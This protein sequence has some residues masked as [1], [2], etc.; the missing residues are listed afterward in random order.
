MTTI[1]LSCRRHALLVD[2][3]ASR[4]EP[5]ARS[6]RFTIFD[7]RRRGPAESAALDPDDMILVHDFAPEEISNN[8][9]RFVADELLPILVA[10]AAGARGR[11]Q[12][13]FERL[14]GAIV[15]SMD[16]DER[17]AWHLF[18]D[19][20]LAAL[21]RA[22]WHAD[23]GHTGNPVPQD[24]ITDFAAIYRRTAELAAEIAP[25]TLIDVATCF[26]FLPLLLAEGAWQDRSAPPT[27]CRIIACDINP[28]LVSLAG[29]YAQRQRLTNVHFFRADILA[30]DLAYELAPVAT[31]FDVV[32]A[33]HFLEHLEPRQSAAA[34]D[35]LWSL[36]RQRLIVAVPMEEVPD[37]RFGHRQVFDRQSLTALA[38]RT[39]GRFETFEDHGA[40]LVIDRAGTPGVWN[41]ERP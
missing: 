17:R 29:A 3:L 34:I 4:V 31:C 22:G 27:P 11:E 21:I 35:A 10:D 16:G 20:T 39:D 26:G 32:S 12:E 24:F 18:Y 19:N 6:G 9:G 38:R 23:G 2:C 30:A 1:T 36:T 8:I 33:I 28:A 25:E 40:W 15:R 7:I 37:A 14:V 5:L 41:E 13:L